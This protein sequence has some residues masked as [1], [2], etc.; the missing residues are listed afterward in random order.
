[1]NENFRI[2]SS[3]IY[4]SPQGYT[5]NIYAYYSMYGW[6]TNPPPN[7]PQSTFNTPFN[8]VMNVCTPVCSNV[9]DRYPK[10]CL[11]ECRR[12]ASK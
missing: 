11:S 12:F 4:N 9:N 5:G 10:Y 6:R 8:K 3:Q 1:M 7:Y 2:K